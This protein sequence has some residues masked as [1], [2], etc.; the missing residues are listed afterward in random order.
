MCLG[1]GGTV[2]IKTGSSFGKHLPILLGVRQKP[3]KLYGWTYASGVGYTHAQCGLGKVRVMCII[4]IMQE[5]I[6]I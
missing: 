1:G 4:I 3:K 2:K 5:L 6:L